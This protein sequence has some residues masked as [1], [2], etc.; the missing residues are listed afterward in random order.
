GLPGGVAA[1]PAVIGPDMFW[2]AVVIRAEQNA[3][4]WKGPIRITGRA[5]VE[6]RDVAHTAAAAEMLWQMNNNDPTPSRLA[7]TVFLAV[8][9]QLT[10]PAR[11][12]ASQ[13]DLRMARGGKLT[14]PLKLAKQT[15]WKGN[16]PV[17]VVGLPP[18]INKNTTNVSES[19]NEGKIELDIQQNAAPGRYTVFLRGDAEI[20][21]RRRADLAD[22]ALADRDRINQVKQELE[23]EY[24]TAV[25][26]RQTAER[27][28]QQAVQTQNTATNEKNQAD[29]TAQQT[30]QQAQQTAKQAADAQTAA[31]EAAKRKTEGEAKLKA[32]T[33]DNG[34]NQAQ[35]ELN[36]LTQ[37]AQSAQTAFENADRQAKEAATAAAQAATKLEEAQK[38]LTAAAEAAVK[39]EEEKRLATE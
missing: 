9:D 30:Q 3:G 25:G 33:D 2:G 23:K 29:Q 31:Q 38:K 15:D 7:S 4:A 1:D 39:A 35:T 34:R 11:V 6:N 5:K 21:Y 27:T 24:Q 17:A 28:Q 14:I 36:A 20:D 16:I 22:R 8:D 13:T 26:Q 12:E 37:A 32:A 18:G 19:G 10:L